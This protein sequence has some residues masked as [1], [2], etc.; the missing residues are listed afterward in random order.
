MKKISALLALGL[1]LSL[2]GCKDDSYTSVRHSKNAETEIA[3]EV[4]PNEDQDS[5]KENVEE[6]EKENTEDTEKENNKNVTDQVKEELDDGVEFRVEDTVNM[7]IAPEKDAYIVTEVGPEDEILN[8]GENNGWT[9]VTA[10]G[11]TGYIRSD[12]LIK[13]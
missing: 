3:E 11:K 4:K 10:K 13:N 8:L 9:R 1:I 7:R 5:K 12:L 6:T 2:T